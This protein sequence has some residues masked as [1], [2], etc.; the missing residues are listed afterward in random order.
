MTFGGSKR[1]NL[2][3]ISAGLIALT[4]AWAVAKPHQP[5]AEPAA[6]TP[7]AAPAGNTPAMELQ[8][9]A[10]QKIRDL[11]LTPEQLAVLRKQAATTAATRPSQPAPETTPGYRAALA[12]L[13]D[14]LVEGDDE[15]TSDAL[16]KVERMRDEQLIDTGPDIDSTPAA[17][18]AAPDVLSTFSSSQIA[19][20][21]AEHADDVPD[22]WKTMLDALDQSREVKPADYPALRKE[23]A[24]QVALLMVGLD[25]AA[26]EPMERKV[27]DW[28]D[29]A[30]AMNDDD[31]KTK[32]PQ[33]EDDA[34]Q[35]VG[36]PD[37]FE[38]MRHW[39]QRET[40]DL[41]SNPELSSALALIK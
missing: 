25:G 40:A 9:D 8:V 24:S 35:I 10:L 5:A 33:V 36:H 19:E 3:V 28:L 38:Q 26:A 22:A 29:Q 18:K 23:A 32:R 7:A 6:P 20:Y 34:R 4:V 1:A 30:H 37:A 2:S 12:S 14:A 13:R 41:L 11:E 31:F 15:K 17:C 16:D 39:M 27:G 21:L